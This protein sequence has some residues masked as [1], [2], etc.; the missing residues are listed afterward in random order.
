MSLES[1]KK[2]EHRGGLLEAK[3]AYS[4]LLPMSLHQERVKEST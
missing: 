4:S 3:D 2:A 1:V